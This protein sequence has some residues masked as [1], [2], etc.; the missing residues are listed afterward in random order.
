ML[1]AFS[2]LCGMRKTAFLPC[3]PTRGTTVPAV[4]DWIHEIK[5][6]GYRPIV[7]RDGLRVRLFT[8]NGHDWSG[9]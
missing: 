9:R 6:D 3:I 4:E 5:H 8:R 2:Y 1:A 7:Q